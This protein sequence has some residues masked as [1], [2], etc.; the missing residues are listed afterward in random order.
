MGGHRTFLGTGVKTTDNGRV[1]D[2]LR[3]RG[4]LHPKNF[5]HP[6]MDPMRYS[7]KN[8]EFV[9][10]VERIVQEGP[11]PA[12]ILVRK[13]GLLAKT[14]PEYKYLLA[15][16]GDGEDGVKDEEPILETVYGNRRL[17]GLIEAMK[18]WDQNPEKKKKVLGDVPARQLAMY[19]TMKDEEAAQEFEDENYNRRQP[20]IYETQ[21]TVRKWLER[22]QTW[23][24]IAE[25]LHLP[26]KELRRL[27]NP[28]TEAHLA[29]VQA[30]S[31]GE[32]TRSRLMQITKLDVMQQAQALDKPEII[33]KK[34][35]RERTIKLSEIPIDLLTSLATFCATGKA[36]DMDAIRKNGKLALDWAEKL[37]G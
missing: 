22:G 8:P 28:L 13:R 23:D 21:L 27:H 36:S 18:I 16:Y 19:R 33:P 26:E 1:V 5:F 29:V 34:P 24:E 20:S 4:I 11:I 32:I 6:R 30:F 17:Y 10:L 15:T 2:P 14:D 3:I 25:R 12:P 31:E 7:M 37:H 9:Q 35:P